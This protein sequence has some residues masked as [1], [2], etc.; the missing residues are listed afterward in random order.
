M[1]H[2]QL[3]WLFRLDLNG[4]G[5]IEAKEFADYFGRTLSADRAEFEATIKQFLQVAA[6][7][8]APK[9]DGAFKPSAV[10]GHIEQMSNKEIKVVFFVVSVWPH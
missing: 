6:L 8:A 9:P 1:P 3:T 5:H 10:S 7:V 2:A 4:S